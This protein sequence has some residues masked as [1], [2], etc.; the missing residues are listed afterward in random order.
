MFKVI[1]EI[2]QK[3]KY[4]HIYNRGN[5][6]ENIFLTPENR[7]YFIQLYSKHLANSVTT[8]AFCLLSN[9][10]HFA[11]RI[12]KENQEVTQSFSNFFNAYAKAFNKA[13]NRTGSLFEKNFKRIEI[14]SESYLRNL[15]LYIHFNP[16]LHF[17]VNYKTF[18][19]SSYPQ[20]IINN[21]NLIDIQEII[22]L[23]DSIEN[24]K[25]LHETQ[26][27]NLEEKYKLE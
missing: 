9:H 23:F 15:I 13:N 14:N 4:Y 8:L 24:F 20:I 25:L 16:Q 5:N 18:P 1:M 12:E 11:V 22:R 10:F 27:S 21:S 17:E 19:F 6:R 2:L 7:R 3:D 26:N